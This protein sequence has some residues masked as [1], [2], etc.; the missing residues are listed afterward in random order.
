MEENMPTT[1]AALT[2]IPIFLP[3]KLFSMFGLDHGIMPA[4]LVFVHFFARWP[5]T[6]LE[7]MV[8]LVI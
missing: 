1:L 8:I 6:S 5:S 7:N 2:K 3:T 4:E